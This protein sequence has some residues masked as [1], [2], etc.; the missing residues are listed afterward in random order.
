[1]KALLGMGFAAAVAVG[2]LMAPAQAMTV[3]PQV[4]G[5]S[6]ILNVDYSCGPGWH[7]GYDG[8]CYRNYAYQPYYNRPCPYGWH[9]GEGRC[10]RNW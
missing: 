6:S 1:M 9:Y 10:W 4:P 3:L 2:S 7:R 8:Y 5:T